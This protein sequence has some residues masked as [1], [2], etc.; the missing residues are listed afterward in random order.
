MKRFWL[1]LLSLGLIVA[2]S[3]SAMAVDVKFSGEYY[4]AGM[5]LDKISFQ[6]H[7]VG[8]S[9]AFYFQR[10]RVRTDFIV[11]PGLSLV[12]R[13]DAME[14]A[15][16]ASRTA[17]GTGLDTQSQGT[18]AEN[19]NIAFDM[20]YVSYV[21]PIGV[22]GVGYQGESTWG[23]VF[24][25]SNTSVGKITYTL[26]V[27]NFLFLVQLV[28]HAELSKTAKLPSPYTDADYNAFYLMAIY[29]LK[30]GAIGIANFAL[31]NHTNRTGSPLFSGVNAYKTEIPLYFVPYAQLKFGPVAVQAELAYQ[32]G[33]RRADGPVTPGVN[34]DADIS[35]LAGWLDV[36]ADF[37]I[38]YVG[39]TFAYVSADDP[40]TTD[41]IEGGFYTGGSDFN[42]CLILWNY[43][44]AYWAGN[45]NGHDSTSNGITFNNGF[46]YQIRAGV[47][48]VDKLDIMASVT[49]ARAERTAN[50]NPFSVPPG[51][52][53]WQGRD[54]GYEVDL[55]ATYK[56]TNNLSYML[57]GGYVFTGDFYKGI[58]ALGTNEVQNDF[59][60]I[61][62]LTLTF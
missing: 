50:S 31:F 47:R 16:G 34:D 48:P 60:V 51:T 22:F 54:Y 46:L 1:V 32:N 5:Y 6:K 41:K 38:A 61:N 29:K 57:G 53:Q 49:Y 10:L 13:F 20:A 26:P 30:Y 52:G 40:S 9:T 62:K 45:I 42:P 37:G 33:K 11:S 2:F 43:D 36:V 24:G 18:V 55:T 19:E 8:Q 44:R 4:A 58:N 39:G 56:I 59:L 27:S 35:T 12:T 28:K 21:S 7:D 14:R 3:T 17:P 23:T 15:W 25:N